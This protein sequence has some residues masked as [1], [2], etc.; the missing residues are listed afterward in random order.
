MPTN[1]RQSLVLGKRLIFLLNK[2][3][4][5]KQ[6]A[7]QNSPRAFKITFLNQQRRGKHTSQS[8]QEQLI[9]LPKSLVTVVQNKI[10]WA[11]QRYE[12]FTGISEIRLIQDKVLEAESEFVEI[13]KDRRECHEQID[14]I[15]NGVKN[16]RDKLE[17]TP[18][19]SNNYVELIKIEHKLLN[20]QIALESKLSQLKN[21]E[22]L[23][24][25]TLSKLLRR[26]HELERLRQEKS[27]YGQIISIALSLVASMVALIA[28]KSRD[29][30]S[31]LRHLEALH[32]PLRQ[33]NSR[34]EKTEHQ[35]EMIERDIERISKSLMHLDS[36]IRSTPKQQVQSGW[37][38]YLPGLSFFTSP[39]RFI[40]SK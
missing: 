35:L 9:A 40:Y 6:L 26:S 32:E 38:S 30:S 37:L 2:N 17:T 15:K 28:Q 33:I 3:I 13:S 14:F 39:F 25:D 29:Q 19:E 20:E 10:S 16:L 1:L 36:H 24:F 22:Q 27:K 23:S 11:N 34:V 12:N 4:C 7:T 21:K 31:T 8:A 5:D 18:R